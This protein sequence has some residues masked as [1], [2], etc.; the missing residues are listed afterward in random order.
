MN[1][2][3]SDQRSR[4]VIATYE[5][6]RAVLGAIE[7]G[8]EQGAKL[9][10]PFDEQVEVGGTRHVAVVLREGKKFNLSGRVTSVRKVGGRPVGFYLLVESPDDRKALGYLHGFCSG[11]YEPPKRFST[12]LE[13]SICTSAS[14]AAGRVRDLSLTGAFVTCRT[15]LSLSK[16]ATIDLEFAGG[17][18]GLGSKR[19]AAK[20]IWRGEKNGVPG[21]GVRFD[22]GSHS[23]VL[24]LMRKHGIGESRAPKRPR[25]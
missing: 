15:E 4:S 7:Q 5:S 16:G 2:D 18:F 8:G 17:F 6:R 11:T 3:L 25:R 22:A 13:C 12:S 14:K 9:Y 1:S 20:V 10:V 19:L 21:F 23:D 24:N